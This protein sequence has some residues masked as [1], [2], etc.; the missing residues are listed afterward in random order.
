MIVDVAS[1]FPG[2]ELRADDSRGGGVVLKPG[3]NFV[4]VNAYRAGHVQFDFNTGAPAATI[5]P[6]TISYH[7]N[8]GGVMHAEVKVLRTFTVMGQV[9]DADGNGARG[10]HVINHAGRSVSQDEG[11][12]TVELS[13]REP[14]VELRHP[15]QSGCTLSLDESRYPRE[16]DVLMVGGLQCP[17]Q[18]AG[19]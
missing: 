13:A 10:V 17:V 7:L 9:L 4:P 12:F 3:R 14:V 6:A 5:Q 15:D 19:Y 2:L 16:G 18:M 1:D 11:F 8:K